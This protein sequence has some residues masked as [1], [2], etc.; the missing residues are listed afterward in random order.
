MVVAGYRYTEANLEQQFEQWRLRDSLQATR[1]EGCWCLGLGGRGQEILRDGLVCTKEYCA[2]PEGATLRTTE[3][4]TITVRRRAREVAMREHIWL[5]AN[6]PLRF[7]G[8]RLETSPLGKTQAGLLKRLE[9]PEDIWEN[10]SPTDEQFEVWSAI[11][12]LWEGSWFFHGAY[13]TG[14]TGLATSLAY[15]R[16]EAE[17]YGTESHPLCTILFTTVPA[18]LSELRS[19]YGRH[20]EGKPTEQEVLRKYIEAELLIMDDIGAEQVKDSG[21]VEDRLYQVIGERHDQLRSTIFTS[22]LGL[23]QLAQR[24][25]ERIVWR[26]A[27]MCGP[28]NVVEL[29]GKNLR[30]VKIALVT[31]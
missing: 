1:P 12:A 21:W 23:D 10:N 7:R 14:K 29:K 5:S 15:A 25:G 16:L 28:T 31:P 11:R 20:E 9:G 3:Q 18:M 22:N 24:I 2:C 8:M 19:T 30:A 17:T 4:E 27:E 26:I 6:I 13:G